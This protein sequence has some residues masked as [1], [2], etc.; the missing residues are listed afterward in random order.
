MKG[1]K[2]DKNKDGSN[3]IFYLCDR[4]ICKK[5]NDVCKHTKD[6]SHAINFEKGPDGGYWEKETVSI[7]KEGVIK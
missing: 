1:L 2:R 6:I 4:R 3:N 5:C 7:T